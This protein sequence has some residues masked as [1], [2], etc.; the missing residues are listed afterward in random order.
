MPAAAPLP[1]GA[2]AT[3]IPSS[4]LKSSHKSAAAPEISEEVAVTKL[5]QLFPHHNTNTVSENNISA[6]DKT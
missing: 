3:G 4:S 2:A 1:K 6:S 5:P